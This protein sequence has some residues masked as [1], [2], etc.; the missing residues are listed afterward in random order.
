MMSKERY[1]EIDATLGHLNFTALSKTPSAVESSD[2][3]IY[4]HQQFPTIAHT[5]NA[6]PAL[7]H[8]GQ[9]TLWYNLVSM[10][11][12]TLMAIHSSF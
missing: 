7:V 2:Y 8:K 9:A 11:V 10:L 12:L 6:Y 5:N 1:L 4:F 3:K